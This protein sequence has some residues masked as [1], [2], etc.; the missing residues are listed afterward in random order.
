MT[1]YNLK[2]AEVHTYQDAKT[3]TVCGD[4]YMIKETPYYLFGAIAD[5]LGSGVKANEVSTMITSYLEE[6]HEQPLEDLMKEC[7]KLMQNK[8]GVVLSLFKADYQKREI[9][10]SGIGNISFVLDNNEK[11]INP[12]PRN[13]FLSGRPQ[14]I[15][16][17]EFSYKPG[18]SFIFYSD[19]LKW[20]QLPKRI[21]Q[22]SLKE[23]IQ[24]ITTQTKKEKKDDVTVMLGK[25][26]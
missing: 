14:S 3:G 23:A 10:F 18:A 22:M 4:S 24:H 1:V 26:V 15:R 8:R 11:T 7:N 6:N 13:G 21:N 16:V 19:G 12:V 17:E 25:L 5:G 20:H 2:K 9:V